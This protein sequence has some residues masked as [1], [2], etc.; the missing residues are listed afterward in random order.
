MGKLNELF[1]EISGA[2]RSIVA[3]NSDITR[4]IHRKRTRLLFIRGDSGSDIL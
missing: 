3:S 4:D 2:I 1:S